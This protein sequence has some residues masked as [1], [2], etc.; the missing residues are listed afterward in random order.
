[1]GDLSWVAPCREKIIKH[2]IIKMKKQSLLEYE[3]P[4]I[5]VHEVAFE[6]DL[7]QSKIEANITVEDLD[8]ENGSDHNLEF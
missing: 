7:C 2:H 6:G 3:T 1:V 8:E 5:V 4:F